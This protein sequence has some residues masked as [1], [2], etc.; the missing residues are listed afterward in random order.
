[1]W[2]M[3]LIR[4][5]RGNLPSPILGKV[6]LTKVDEA[7]VDTSNYDVKSGSTVV[8]LKESHFAVLPVGVHTLTF[9]YNDGEVS[10]HFMIAERETQGTPTAV[11][12][13]QTRD[14][15]DAALW[16]LLLVLPALLMAFAV[17]IRKQKT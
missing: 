16:A 8:T 7:S 12:S 9:V 3:L 10:T 1:M 13:P 11:R 2:D 4:L 17:Q 6:D 14:N 5:R 15:A